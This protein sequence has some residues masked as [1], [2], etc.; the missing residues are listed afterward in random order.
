MEKLTKKQAAVLTAFTGIV[1]GSF[2]DFHG[3]AEVIL[4]RPIF[5]HEFADKETA[6]LLKECSRA[7]FLELQP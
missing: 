7:D 5:T 1:M 2:T 4:G 6:D 3:Y